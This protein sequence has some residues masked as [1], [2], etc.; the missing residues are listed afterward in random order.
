MKKI[1]SLLLA[2]TML[3]SM[4]T[5]AASA[6]ELGSIAFYDAADGS[7]VTYLD[8][9]DN[10]YANVTFTAK[11]DAA[12]VIAAHYDIETGALVEME[13]LNSVNT[14]AGAIVSYNTPEI[15]VADTDLL[16]VYAWDEA[17]LAPLT[18]AGTIERD[19]LE[20][21][22]TA[23]VSAIKADADFAL[24]F[25]ADEV[26]DEQLAFYGDWKAD[27][28]FT[29]NK[30]ATFNADGSKD[31]YLIGQYDEF[32]PEPVKI[33]ATDLAVTAGEGVSILETA[34]FTVTYRDVY[35]TVKEF[36]CGVDFSE[37]YL[38]A[39]NGLEVSL[40]L[41]LVNPENGN[42]YT[43]AEKAFDFTLPT[44][45]VTELDV[46]D[47]K[48]VPL[49][50]A[51]N[52]KADPSTESQLAMFGDWYADYEIT[53]NKTATFNL[54]GTE[55]GYLAGQYDSWSPAWVQV[56]KMDITLTPG[57]PLKIME[58]AAKT[59][60]KPGLK[61]TYQEVYDKVKDFDCGIYFS[62]E[63]LAANDGLE[64]T[65]CLKMYNPANEA[66]SYVIGDVYTYNWTLPTAT[67]TH[68]DTNNLDVEADFA[69][70]FKANEATEEQL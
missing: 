19:L 12:T 40:A 33:P 8:G 3:A 50:Y 27:F 14:T 30:D 38:E 56:P 28:V 57:T 43:I 23:T 4:F 25:V 2:M 45:T 13:F 51:L 46:A 55:D 20:E 32:G 26:T 1:L 64:V 22:P 6:N 58:T 49:T 44:A 69:M 68:L 52:F 62:P 18:N 42:T 65:L 15:S 70:N 37:A 36:N 17:T 66:E 29:T 63:F 31:G 39:N 60:G 24:N 54:D 21:L 9:V 41:V 5:V 67:V 53:I 35:E 47:I 7:I 16:K 59:Y 11:G 48:D 34:G 61:Y 10:V